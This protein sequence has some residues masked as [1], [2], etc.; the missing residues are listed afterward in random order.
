VEVSSEIWETLQKLEESLWRRETR[1]D[2]GY[3]SEIL[4]ADYFE[5]GRSGRV[6]ARQP[7][8]DAPAG[9]IE[10]ELPLPDL[11]M[12]HLDAG[13]VLATYRS[14]DR[15]GGKVRIARRCSIWSQTPDG[16]RLRFHQGT[17][18]GRGGR[19]T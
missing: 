2:R 3:M 10:A 7:T 1:F 8:L 16:W 11:R 4:A 12:R 18:S 19:E 13:V 17:P 9:D 15:Y 5:I 14:E 6:Y